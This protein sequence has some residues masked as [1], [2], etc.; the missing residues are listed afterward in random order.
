ML[1]TC[2]RLL[3]WLIGGGEHVQEYPELFDVWD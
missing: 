2:E 1:A 3:H